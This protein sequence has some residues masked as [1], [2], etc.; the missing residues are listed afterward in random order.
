MHDLLSRSIES[1]VKEYG[2]SRLLYGSGFPNSY[3]GANMLMIKHA[4]ICEDDKVAIAG[5]N[6]TRVIE[7]VS[8]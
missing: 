7:G 3:F 6:L 5:G 8:I 4:D 2:S 1:F